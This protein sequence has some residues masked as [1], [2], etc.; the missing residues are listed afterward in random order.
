MK[1][2]PLLLGE[3]GK[4]VTF[5]QN[6]ILRHPHKIKIG[7]NVV[8]DD[9]VVLVYQVEPTDINVDTDESDFPVFLTKYIAYDTLE[10]AYSVN[11]DGRIESLR[12]YWAYR[13]EVGLKMVN[14]YKGLRKQDRDYRF[15]SQF[16]G[17][18]KTR[19]HPRLPSEYPAI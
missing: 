14:R 6:V 8:I 15:T 16:P 10:Q 19:R 9:N 12:E 18:R 7:D 4:N 3:V 5:G 1:L 2:Y 13:K 17:P 11:N